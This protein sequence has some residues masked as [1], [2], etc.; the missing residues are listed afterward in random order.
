MLRLIITSV[1]IGLMLM[2]STAV[3]QSAK[4]VGDIYTATT[5]PGNTNVTAGDPWTPYPGGTIQVDPGE[6]IWIGVEN[7]EVPVAKK[8]LTLTLTGSELDELTYVS[9]T[10]YDADGNSETIAASKTT[11]VN[12][13]AKSIY[14]FLFVPQPE[15]EVIEFTGGVETVYIDDIVVVSSCNVPTLTHWG[16]LVL[17][18]LLVAGSI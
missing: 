1:F 14:Q 6:Q 2:A 13:F 15:W 18:L 5:D 17:V 8:R 12:G 16:L 9:V 4:A 10:G 7:R 3:A 11:E